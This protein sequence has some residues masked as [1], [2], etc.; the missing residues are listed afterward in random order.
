MF[1][2]KLSSIFCQL[3]SLSVNWLPW[4]QLSSLNSQYFEL[5]QMLWVLR[6]HTEN[7]KLRHS[8]KWKGLAKSLDL[9]KKATSA[10]KC[11]AAKFW[12][13]FQAKQISV[14]KKAPPTQ[15]E[16]LRRLV[17]GWTMPKVAQMASIFTFAKKK[18]FAN[19][20][21]LPFQV[22][23]NRKVTSAA[24]TWV[25]SKLW[26]HFMAFVLIFACFLRHA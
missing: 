7:L 8:V 2:G 18:P 12:N 15:V 1:D 19:G 22:F 26:N 20:Y 4:F 5:L 21:I 14:R 11:D 9:P 10:L 3:C 17:L 16:R 23:H 13:I 24:A 25:C 6:V